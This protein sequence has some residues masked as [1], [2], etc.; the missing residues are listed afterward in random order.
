MQYPQS[1]TDYIFSHLLPELFLELVEQLS[2]P[3]HV[4]LDI[5]ADVLLS[6][7]ELSDQRLI[8]Q[9][10]AHKDLHIGAGLGLLQHVGAATLARLGRLVMGRLARNKQRNEGLLL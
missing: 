4:L 5:G 8:L 1:S 7:L 3:L 2:E 9:R 10:L 6:S